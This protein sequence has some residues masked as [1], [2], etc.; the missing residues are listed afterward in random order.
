MFLLELE[1]GI[2]LQVTQGEAIKMGHGAHAMMAPNGKKAY[3][4]SNEYLKEVDLETLKSRE[5]MW[6]PFS[7][8]LPIL[9]R[10]RLREQENVF[11]RN[12][13]VL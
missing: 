2:A 5:L 10:R 1:N 11:L 9:Y 4:Y 6:I 7:Y 13:V 3:Y 8:N 12:P